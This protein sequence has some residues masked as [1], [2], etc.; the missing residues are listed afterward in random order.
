MSARP[1]SPIETRRLE[2]QC[3]L[4]AAKTQAERNRMGQ[5]ATPTALAR[6][7]LGYAKRQLGADIGVRFFDPAIGTGSFYSALLEVFP[8]QR[9]TCQRH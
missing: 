8:E 2:L 4:D 6:D 9:G 3:D 7:I 1:Q 5:F